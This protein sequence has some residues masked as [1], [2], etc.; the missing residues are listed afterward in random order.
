[1]FSMIPYRTNRAVA[2]HNPTA[3]NPF[4]DDFFRSFFGDDF[5]NGMLGAERPMKVDVKDEGDHY[6]LEAD[7]PG[8]SKENV[9]IS[10]DNGVLTIAAETKQETDKEEKGKYIYRERRYGRTSR[11]FNLEGI[12]ESGIQAR[13]ENGVLA[14]TL[15]KEKQPEQTSRE[16]TIQ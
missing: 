7:A 9:K 3:Y 12:D 16:I 8:M 15:P 6:L 1:M 14:L 11:S 5:A 2:A 4:S 10:V 13:F